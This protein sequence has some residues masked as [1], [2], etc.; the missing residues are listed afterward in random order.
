MLESAKNRVGHS[1]INENDFGH[2]LIE[3]G[4]QTLAEVKFVFFTLYA[5]VC[6]D[7]DDRIFRR[8]QESKSFRQSFC[9]VTALISPTNIRYDIRALLLKIMTN[10]S[11]AIHVYHLHEQR[12]I[13]IKRV[14][15]SYDGGE[16]QH[17]IDKIFRFANDVG[18]INVVFIEDEAFGEIFAG[19][20]RE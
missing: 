11:V 3:H 6:A 15:R 9:R 2:Q 10:C 8:A 14:V 13:A 20:R 17:V 12:S 19:S 1:P 18:E 4:F 5:A 7:R 16:A